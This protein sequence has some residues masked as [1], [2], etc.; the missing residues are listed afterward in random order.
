MW[1]YF[2]TEGFNPE[3]VEFNFDFPDESENDEA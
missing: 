2:H 3:D 1:R